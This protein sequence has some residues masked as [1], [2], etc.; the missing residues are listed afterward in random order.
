MWTHTLDGD[1]QEAVVG[2]GSQDIYFNSSTT[3]ANLFECGK[4]LH[5]THKKQQQTKS[6]NIYISSAQ[7]LLCHEPV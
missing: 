1:N 6:V 4:M 3:T 5:S 2:L 7:P